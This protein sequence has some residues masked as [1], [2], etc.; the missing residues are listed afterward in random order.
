MSNEKIILGL[1]IGAHKVAA[2]IYCK[3]IMSAQHKV[4]PEEVK[5]DFERWFLGLREFLEIFLAESK[6]SVDAVGVGVA[7]IIQEGKVIKSPNL[8]ILDNQDLKSTFGQIFDKEIRFDNDVN[9]FLRAE[10]RLGAAQGLKN[11]V[12]IT[13]GTGV[14]GA[15]LIDGKIYQGAHD[16][17]GEIGYMIIEGENTLEDLVS[18]RGF[19]RLSDKGP[20]ELAQAARAGDKEAQRVFNEIGR[21][22]GRGL[23][24]IVNLVDP[25]AI[26]LGGGIVL[27]GDLLLEPA[28]EE[29]KK[30][31]LSPS[32]KEVRLLFGQFKEYSAALGAA[33]LF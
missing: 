16:S 17:A 31:I 5:Q 9:C 1:D 27:T 19:R 20:E 29:L 7:G 12:G 21:Y 32:A 23:G 3:N 24:N 28:R 2:V 18:G 15:L 11:V 4:Y 6:V 8:S 14:G 26:V 22:L 10:S 33:L 13:L 30:L 25:E